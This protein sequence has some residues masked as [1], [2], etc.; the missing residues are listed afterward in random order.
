MIDVLDLLDDP[1]ECK[2]LDGATL[3]RLLDLGITWAA[4]AK[5]WAV[6]RAHV[7]FQPWADRY[8][9]TCAG[10]PALIFGV[11]DD[12][13]LV[14]LAAWWPKGNRI[15]TRI[16]VGACLGQGQVGRGGHGMADQPLPVFRTPLAWLQRNR[17]GLVVADRVAAAHLLVDKAITGE[18]AAHDDDLLQNLTLRPPLIV[19]TAELAV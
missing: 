14:D 15:G 19:R 2:A 16:G 13:E 8:F 18:D 6:Q 12:G 3:K 10:E 11:I 5:P 4:L 7:C 9:P 1:T 17:R